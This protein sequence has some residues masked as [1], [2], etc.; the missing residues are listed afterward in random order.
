[1]LD[2][3]MAFLVKFSGKLERI[4]EKFRVGKTIKAGERGIPVVGKV[5]DRTVFKPSR[6]VITTAFGA[7]AGVTPL[8]T[9]V[10]IKAGVGIAKGTGRELNEEVQEDGP[11]F[12]ESSVG[13]DHTADETRRTL[14]I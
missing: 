5:A 11:F 7:S 12:D 9:G 14:D 4:T 6:R 1:L 13:G 3:F 10:G 8:A 2:Q